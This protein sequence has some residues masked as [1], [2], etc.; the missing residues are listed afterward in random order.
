M[1]SFRSRGAPLPHTASSPLTEKVPVFCPSC[2][3]PEIVTTAKSPDSSSYWRCT[4]CGEVWND[5]RSD[6]A[7]R[8]GRRTWR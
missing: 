8:S 6:A 5:S 1:A 7:A 4:K 3:S 2:R